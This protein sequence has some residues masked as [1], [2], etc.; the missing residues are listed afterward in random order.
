[1]DHRRVENWTLRRSLG[2]TEQFFVIVPQR[3]GLLQQ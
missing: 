3:K 2:A 1:M